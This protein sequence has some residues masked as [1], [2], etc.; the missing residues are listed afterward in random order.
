M[1]QVPPVV[2]MKLSEEV[3]ALHHR[4]QAHGHFGEFEP[5][6][7]ALLQE[8]SLVLDAAEMVRTLGILEPLTGIH[9]PPDAIQ[10][11]GPNYRESLIANGLLC[12]NRAVLVV[13]EQLY[14]SL[15]QLAQQEIY[16]VEALTGFA[17]WLRR[18]LGSERL[19]CSEYLVDYD[20]GLSDIPH[21]DLCA[22]TF[23]DASFDLVLCNELFEHVQDL[24]LC[25]R[26]IARVLRPGGRLVGTCPMAFGQMEAIVKAI[27]NPATGAPELL[28]EPEWHGDPV[29]P[30]EGALV[31]RI[32]GWDVLEQLQAAGFLEARIHHIASWKHGV[33]G[34]DLPGVLVLEAQR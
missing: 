22:L 16:L 12:R 32:P 8:A 24:E 6:L 13:L 23:P 3:L 34:S 4:S 21:Q 11:Q 27:H 17:L 31:Y 10:I 20:G 25:F 30:K 33:L 26:E 14:G 2:A 19:T 29:R 5:H 9:I 15:A 28:M 7:A 18:Q 1:V